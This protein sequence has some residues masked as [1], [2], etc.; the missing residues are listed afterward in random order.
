MCQGNVM[1]VLINYQS[2]SASSKRFPDAK[3]V[4]FTL[5]L[6][7]C[8]AD[9]FRNFS[10]NQTHTQFFSD[11]PQCKAQMFW[12]EEWIGFVFVLGFRLNFQLPIVA[13]C[14]VHYFVYHLRLIDCYKARKKSGN[15]SRLAAWVVRTNSLDK[16]GLD[17]AL[18]SP[19][20]S[21]FWKNATIQAL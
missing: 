10:K 18:S 2:C 19:N 8:L 13:F 12:S 9:I 5:F 11:W 17:K 4:G 14:F 20:R 1:F 15:I 3:R 6:N 7:G 16:A 21:H